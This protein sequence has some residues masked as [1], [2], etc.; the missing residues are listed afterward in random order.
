MKHLTV[1]LD[2]LTKILFTLY[3]LSKIQHFHFIIG[4]YLFPLIILTNYLLFTEI[5]C[6]LVQSQVGF[7]INSY[8]IN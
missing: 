4:H 8:F 1:I 3:H 7:N 5:K 2:C 6:L